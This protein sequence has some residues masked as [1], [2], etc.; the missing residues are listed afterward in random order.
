MSGLS[1]VAKFGLIYVM[2]C[3]SGY[4]SGNGLRVFSGIFWIYYNIGVVC[5]HEYTGKNSD[6]FHARVFLIKCLK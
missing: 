2:F 4:H 3:M 1:F 6:S 5:S